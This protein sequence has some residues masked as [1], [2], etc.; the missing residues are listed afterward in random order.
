MNSSCLCGEPEKVAIAVE[1]PFL[2]GRLENAK[3]AFI[4]TKQH[5]FVDAV[6]ILQRNGDCLSPMPR[7]GNDF[8]RTARVRSIEACASNDIFESGGH[9]SSGKA[10][11]SAFI[12][13]FAAD[14]SS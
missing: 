9:A 7:D 5:L 6:G 13:C 4:G 1:A 11:C 10:A 8:D 14:K 2:R 12:S 3:G